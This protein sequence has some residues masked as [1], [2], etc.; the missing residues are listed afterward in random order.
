MKA[1]RQDIFSLP[2]CAPSVI[3]YNNKPRTG[4]GTEP[5]KEIM[6]KVTA[7][8]IFPETI[9]LSSFKSKD[10]ENTLFFQS[11]YYKALF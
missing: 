8:V 5:L 11:V 2:G 4:D 6:K 3:L 7:A 9:L 10:L 1:L